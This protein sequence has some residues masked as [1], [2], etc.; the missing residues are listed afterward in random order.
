[1]PILPQFRP[2]RRAITVPL[3]IARNGIGCGIQIRA[4]DRLARLKQT[5]AKL[6]RVGPDA[7]YSGPSPAGLENQKEY[8]VATHQHMNRLKGALGWFLAGITLA[9]VLVVAAAGAIALG[10]AHRRIRPRPGCPI[11]H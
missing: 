3:D 11:H 7:P 1:M 5:I 6:S 9:Y 4:R 8:S 2:G 10:A